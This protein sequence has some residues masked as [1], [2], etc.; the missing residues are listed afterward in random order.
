[1]A[2]CDHSVLRGANADMHLQHPGVS[3]RWLHPETD[4]FWRNGA[5]VIVSGPDV[6]GEG[7]HKVMDFLQTSDF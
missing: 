6:P 1:M 2:V 4:P 5:Q 3:H 7:E